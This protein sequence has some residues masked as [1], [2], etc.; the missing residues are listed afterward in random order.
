MQ[1]KARFIFPASMAFFMSFFMS[2]IITAV[3]LGLDADF[4][5]H[6]MTAWAIAFPLA[7]IAAFFSAPIAGRI[8][9]WMVA[10]L[11]GPGPV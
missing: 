5:L 10:R 1:G 3:N 8:T 4:P 9:R 2:G 7:A 11:D 6:W